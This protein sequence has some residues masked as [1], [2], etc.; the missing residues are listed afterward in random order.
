VG[1]KKKNTSMVLVGTPKEINYLED[2]EVS[3]N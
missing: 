3:G 1:G 2:S